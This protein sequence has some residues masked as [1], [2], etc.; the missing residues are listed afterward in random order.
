MVELVEPVTSM[1]LE[2]PAGLVRVSAEVTDGVVGP[3]T[4][5][6]VPSFCTALDAVVEVPGRRHAARRRRLRRRVVRVRR[7]RPRSG[8]AIVPGR[9][10]RAG[11]AGRADPPARVRA[12]R[13]RAP[14]RAGALATSRSSSSSPRRG[15]A[16]TPATPRSSPPAGSTARPPAPRPPPGIAVLDK[17]GTHGR[18]LRRRERDR[19]DV[20][21][22]GSP[23]ARGS[24]TST[25][26]SPRS[27]AAPGSRAS[28]SSSSTPPTRCADGFKLP[29]TWG[30]G[31]RE[32]TLNPQRSDRHV[33]R[34]RAGRAHV[35]DQAPGRG[36]D[37]RAQA[38]ARAPWCPRRRACGSRPPRT[39]S[40]PP[41]APRAGPSPAR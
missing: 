15:S 17:R 10:A 31:P 33:D 5:E 24:A 22:A 35:Q 13:D 34:L 26:S 3:I 7:R 37:A 36:E 18:A 2:A 16:A 6:N 32:G 41:P 39:S 38:A 21:A 23:A 11:R 4:F 8:F 40:C 19:H 30:P 12:A 29:D 9:G 28:T 1:V 27:P 20:H 14:A 25:R